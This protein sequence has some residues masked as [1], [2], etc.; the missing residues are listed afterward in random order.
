MKKLFHIWELIPNAVYDIR[1]RMSKELK[2]KILHKLPKNKAKIIKKL[3]KS[4]FALQKNIKVSYARWFDW[5][6]YNDVEIPL[7]ALMELTKLAKLS[8]EEME[9]N[10]ICYKK[11]NTPKR[12]Y[13]YSPVLPV[14]F[15]PELV[16]L[17]GHFCFD[18]SLPA[19]GK[20]SFYSQKNIEQV[21]N[22]I[23]KTK[24]CFGEVP[25]KVGKDNKNVH[26]VRLPRIIGEICK[27]V[28]EF[29]SFDSLRTKLPKKIKESNKNILLAFL[30]SA[31]IDEGCVGT[32]YIQI[33][34]KNKRMIEDLRGL[35][36]NLGCACTKPKAKKGDNQV[37]YFYIKSIETIFKGIKRLQKTSTTISFGFKENKINFLISS[38]KFPRGKHSTKTAKTRKQDI[39]ANLK[40]A[41]TSFE[42][43]QLLQVPARSIRRHLLRLLKEGKV[44]RTKKEQAYF[45]K[46][47]P[48]FQG[49]S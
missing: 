46:L 47:S 24:T 44:E 20:G 1:I 33:M 8:F 35:C 7:W 3:N 29:E 25:V 45:Y 2:Q 11:T 21:N 23:E 39:I 48:L 22:F 10:I 13:I 6:E 32:E 34:L 28:C 42:L 9:Q 30:A 27:Y 14:E 37:Y 18:G 17:A 40:E 19:D 16:S 49:H 36:L 5:I 26:N 12:L 43:S 4:R 41:K 31:I 15:S 38:K